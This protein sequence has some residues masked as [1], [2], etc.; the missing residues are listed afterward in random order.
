[1]TDRNLNIRVAFGAVNKLTSPASSAQKSAAALAGQIRDTQS[2]L[3]GM[4]RNASSFDRLSRAAQKT[5]QQ[6]GEA[7]NKAKELR[8]SFGPAK[9][10][11]DEQTAAL[12]QQ[13]EAIRQLPRAQNEEQAKLG[14]LSS[15]MLLHGIVLKTGSSA[16]DQINRRPG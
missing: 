6:L 12:K 8:D 16:T 13:S 14:A 1:M 15:S 9:Q 3:K 4:E 5:T 2:S 10:R 7:K 11:T